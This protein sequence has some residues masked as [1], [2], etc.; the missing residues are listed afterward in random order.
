M[1]IFYVYVCILILGIY[2]YIYTPFSGGIYLHLPP[3]RGNFTY[4]FTYTPRVRGYMHIYTPRVR[5]Y[6]QQY[7]PE[8]G[9]YVFLTAMLE[10]PLK[11]SYFDCYFLMKNRKSSIVKTPT[12]KTQTNE[13]Q[14]YIL[15][16]HE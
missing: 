9:I 10:L 3:T 15:W 14:Q 7:S 2:T 8:L 5:G 1:C 6:T 13:F 4:I 12:M 16:T 11:L